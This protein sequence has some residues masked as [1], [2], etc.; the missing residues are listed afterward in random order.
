MT[1]AR[2][3]ARDLYKLYLWHKHRSHSH[4][5]R[6]TGNKAMM[7]FYLEA[8]K[9]AVC[10]VTYLETRYPYFPTWE[11]FLHYCNQKD[12][13]P[14]Y[15]R[16]PYSRK[17]RRGRIVAESDHLTVWLSKDED[18]FLATGHNTGVMGPYNSIRKAYTASHLEDEFYYRREFVAA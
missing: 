4:G 15:D 13:W 3:F 12:G 16:A 10:Y 11:G 6:T 14:L 18:A 8:W 9:I 5:H 17:L 1:D 7:Q 2:R